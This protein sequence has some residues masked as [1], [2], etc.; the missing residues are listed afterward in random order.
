MNREIGKLLIKASGKNKE[1][2]EAIAELCKV[3]A[4]G[5]YGEKKD[6]GKA[7][8]WADKAKKLK[9]K[10]SED[11]SL[12]LDICKIDKIF[13]DKFDNIQR[14]LKFVGTKDIA[15]DKSS[16]SFSNRFDNIQNN[17]QFVD[18]KDIT[19]KE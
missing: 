9:Q 14:N 12:P 17:L 8:F 10:L 16:K 3:Y 1:A 7:Q 4:Y 5:F 18:T 11:I 19:E 2:L 15:D 13:T 6:L